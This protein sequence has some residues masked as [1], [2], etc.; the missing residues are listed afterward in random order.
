MGFQQVFDALR[1]GGRM[2]I[3]TT[4][5]QKNLDQEFEWPVCMQMFAD[6]DDLRPMCKDVGF[7]DVQIVN[8]ESPLEMELDEN[9]FE[10]DNPERF[11]IHGKYA[12]Q[13]EYLEKMDM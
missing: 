4:T 2:A 7:Q 10:G 1:P 9:I 5:I 12:D 13:Y 11:K 3:S 6:L 8:A